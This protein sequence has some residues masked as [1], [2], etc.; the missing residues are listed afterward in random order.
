MQKSRHKAVLTPRIGIDYME[1]EQRELLNFMPF[2]GSGYSVAFSVEELAPF[3]KVVFIYFASYIVNTHF[4]SDY[5]AGLTTHHRVED[6][7]SLLDEVL[8]NR[9]VFA[10]IL[11]SRNYILHFSSLK[12]LSHLK[13]FLG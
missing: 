12:Y 6:C 13:F 7:F 8:I 2:I 4:M 9:A 10:Y 5:S 11:C 3:I 1:L